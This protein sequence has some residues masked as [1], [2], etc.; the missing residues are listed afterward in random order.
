MNRL[1]EAEP[2][3]MAALL[4]EEAWDSTADISPRNLDLGAFP[5]RQLFV[6][7]HLAAEHEGLAHTV[8]SILQPSQELVDLLCQT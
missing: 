2:L 4:H 8:V 5:T 3:Q 6:A 1:T 7:L